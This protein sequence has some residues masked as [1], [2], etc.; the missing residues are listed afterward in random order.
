MA[1]PGSDAPRS[2][3]ILRPARLWRLL[4]TLQIVKVSFSYNNIDE[5][6]EH[7]FNLMHFFRHFSLNKSVTF[8]SPGRHSRCAKK[9]EKSAH[10]PGF[11]SLRFPTLL[12]IAPSIQRFFATVCPD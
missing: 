2:H 7:G 12:L 5:I 11:L 10:F 3:A 4:V 9:R 8:P 1:I 6:I